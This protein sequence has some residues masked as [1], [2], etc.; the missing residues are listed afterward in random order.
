MKT[1]FDK[2][3]QQS[4]DEMREKYNYSPTVLINM[5]DKHGTIEAVRRLINSSKTPYG[6]TKL[7]ELNALDLSLEAIILEEK[8]K[9]LFSEE[10]RKKAKKKLIKH[11]YKK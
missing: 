3:V 11:D 10:D 2:R 1:D 6:F 8:W 9:N 7:W 4:I 5:I